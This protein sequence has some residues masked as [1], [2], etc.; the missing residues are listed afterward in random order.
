MTAAAAMVW[1]THRSWDAAEVAGALVR[2]ATPLGTGA[3][4]RD[5]G[6]GRLDVSRA[7]RARPPA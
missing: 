1:A 7:L 4:S 6:Y 5:W 3:P 2:T